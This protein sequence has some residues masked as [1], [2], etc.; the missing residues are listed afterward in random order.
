MDIRLKY[1][2]V[3]RN[4]AHFTDIFRLRV[5]LTVQACTYCILKLKKN[6]L[7]FGN[8]EAIEI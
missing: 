2:D 3:I 5:F 6:L 4:N 7:L 8:I 1:N